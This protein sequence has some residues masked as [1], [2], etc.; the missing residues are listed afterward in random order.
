MCCKVTPRASC[1]MG[2]LLAR[3]RSCR[4]GL[5]GAPHGQK[6]LH[7]QFGGQMR[8]SIS[9]GVTKVRTLPCKHHLG[10]EDHGRRHPRVQASAE[11]ETRGCWGHL[12]L[13]AAGLPWFGAS[14]I[15]MEMEKG[16]S[17]LL[18]ELLGGAFPRMVPK[19]Y[20]C[21]RLTQWLS[22]SLVLFTS[23]M[24]GGDPGD[25]RHP[26]KRCIR[27]LTPSSPSASPVWIRHDAPYAGLDLNSGRCERMGRF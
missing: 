8:A 15:G 11:T 25:C 5:C 9:F 13:A 23:H 2:S 10:L 4:H 26:W 14:K 3:T 12:G 24:C 19:G 16:L 22:L 1:Q 7:K 27:R 20:Q 6:C 18:G 21:G 17:V